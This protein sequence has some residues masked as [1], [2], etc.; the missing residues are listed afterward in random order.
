MQKLTIGVGGDCV[1][2]FLQK[3]QLEPE[4]SREREK[5]YHIR[6]IYVDFNVSVLAC[7]TADKGE[8]VSIFLI[9]YHFN[10]NIT[11]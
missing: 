8:R 3:F 9:S 2:E 4:D 5:W 6:T 11:R 10:G 1:R 7:F